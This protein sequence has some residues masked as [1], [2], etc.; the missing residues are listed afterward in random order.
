M[1]K[2][3]RNPQTAHKSVIKREE[4]PKQLKPRKLNSLPHFPSLY[5]CPNN[6]FSAFVVEFHKSELVTKSSL[7]STTRFVVDS[8]LQNT[9][10]SSTSEAN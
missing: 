7:E 4:K 6:E 5:V 9:L 10:M 1:E 2:E 8:N 3:I